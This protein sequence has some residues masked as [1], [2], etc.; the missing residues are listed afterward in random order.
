LARGAA[1][2]ASRIASIGA[3]ATGGADCGDGAKASGAGRASFAKGAGGSTFSGDFVSRKFAAGAAFF[4]AGFGSSL[5]SS[6]SFCSSTGGAAGAAGTGAYLLR[7]GALYSTPGSSRCISSVTPKA[8]TRT[9]A[10][11]T[12]AAKRRDHEGLA[13]ARREAA[14]IASSRARG[15]SSRESSR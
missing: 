5:F 8:S 1:T 6:F 13:T 15:G 2:F 4:N 9:A 10:I 12:G 3:A 11:D 14:R 7:A